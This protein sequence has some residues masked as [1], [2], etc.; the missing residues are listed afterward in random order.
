MLQNRSEAAKDSK[1]TATTH[2]LGGGLLR[3]LELDFEAAGLAACFKPGD[4]AGADGDLTGPAAR[5]HS[6]HSVHDARGHFDGGVATDSGDGLGAGA[7][8]SDIDDEIAPVAGV[9]ADMDF[10]DFAGVEAEHVTGNGHAAS[11]MGAGE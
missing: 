9:S 11:V 7:G 6:Q 4:P 10:D 8:K 3:G 1:I 5:R 2:Q